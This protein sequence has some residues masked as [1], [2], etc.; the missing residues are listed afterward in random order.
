[1]YLIILLIFTWICHYFL[2]YLYD[3]K[4]K[5]GASCS[6][7]VLRTKEE[8][9]FMIMSYRSIDILHIICRDGVS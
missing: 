5:G 7:E 1:M 8:N 3:W 4:I 2:L 6:F 9:P